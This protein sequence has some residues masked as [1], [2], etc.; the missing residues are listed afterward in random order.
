MLNVLSLSV[1]FAITV[2]TIILLKPLSI[3]LGLVDEPGGRKDHQGHVPLIG[4]I[5]ISVG[6]GF[7]LLTLNISLSDYRSFIAISILLIITGLLDDFHELAPRSR[8]LVQLVVGL[9][10]CF[11]GKLVLLHVGNLFNFGDIHLGYFAIPLTVI[12][13][14]GVINA[15]NMTDGLDGLAGSLALIEFIF[16]LWLAIHINASDEIQILQLL[17]ATVIAFLL[18]NF[19][20]PGRKQAKVFMGD[21]GSMLLGFCLVW[22][23]LKLSQGSDTSTLVSPVTF[24]WLTAVPIL[25]IGSVI[26]RRLSHKRSPFSADRGHWH[27]YLQAKGYSSFKAVLAISF[28]AIVS[29]FVGIAGEYWHAPESVMFA[30]FLI[31]FFAYLFILRR[32]WG[33]LSVLQP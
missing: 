26:W 12:A 8:L 30:S 33:K 20:F 23:A 5:A 1:A 29:S 18:F 28:F 24:L 15:F 9:L 32:G 4:G 6:L 10:M 31:V 16:M 25:D 22:F 7:G 21:A 17:I 2:L 14:I 11:W 3:R 13:V 19:P 27:H